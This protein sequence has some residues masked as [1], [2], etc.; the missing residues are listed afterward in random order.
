MAPLLRPERPPTAAR[1]P[2]YPPCPRGYS[3][4]GDVPSPTPASL[5]VHPGVVTLW[6]HCPPRRLAQRGWTIEGGVVTFGGGDE[7]PLQLP[8]SK[9]IQETLSYAKELERIV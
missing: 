9:L 5:R 2:P 7:K 3:S 8:S 6:S 1:P 4:R